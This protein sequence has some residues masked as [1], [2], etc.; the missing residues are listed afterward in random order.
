MKRA[1]LLIFTL[2]C[3][4][5]LVAYTTEPPRLLSWADRVAGG[6]RGVSLVAD[7]VPFG[8]AGQTLNIW[9]PATPTAKPRPVLVF[10]HGGGWVHGDRRAYD[11]AA[12]A[13]AAA[14]YVVVVPDYRKVPGVRFPAFVQD[15]AQAVRWVRDNIARNG[16]DPKRIALAGHSAGAHT[17]AMLAL[18]RR[19]LQAEGVE[20][21]IVRA[22]IP[23]C[24]PYDFY[25]FTKRRAID[26]MAGV[27]DPRFTQP[28]AFARADAPP[29]LLLSA[30]QDVQVGAHNAVNLARRLKSVGAP[31]RHRDYP[32][33]SHEEVVM[34][35]SVPFRDK[36][37]V[38]AE[39]L[40]F[41]KQAGVTP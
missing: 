2:T 24:G 9:A 16:G 20:P 19:W 39:S 12:R 35:L 11:F 8:T 17:V 30:G 41:L 33:L 13:F 22:G 37:P 4:L 15:G 10:F 6:G 40:A 26:A 36:G 34:S 29:L 23:M 7:D 1:L 28:I 18:D 25:P 31:V 3:V 5:G 32:A 38:L 27:R 14:G 21:A